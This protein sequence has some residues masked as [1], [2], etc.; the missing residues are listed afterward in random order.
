MT[1]VEYFCVPTE[2][3]EE[4]SAASVYQMKHLY[5]RLTRLLRL[6]ELRVRNV[7]T[8]SASMRGE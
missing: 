8:A 1:E 2:L 3:F 7:V 5:V 4:F 6:H